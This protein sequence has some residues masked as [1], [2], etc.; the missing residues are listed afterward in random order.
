M[1]PGRLQQRGS[2]TN[3]DGNGLRYVLC[4]KWWLSD[5]RSGGALILEARRIGVLL[6]L[7]PLLLI[8]L[9]L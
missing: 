1:S 9:L 7:V 6:L 8:L 2:R 5:W 4:E 3:K